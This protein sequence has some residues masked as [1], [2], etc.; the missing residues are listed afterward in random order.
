M[1]S[2]ERL[3]CFP[4]AYHNGETSLCLRIA[5]ENLEMESIASSF[6]FYFAGANLDALLKLGNLVY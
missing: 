2:K 5:V 4:T 1:R 3:P 6:A